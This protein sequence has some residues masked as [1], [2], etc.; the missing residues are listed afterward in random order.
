MVRAHYSH[1]SI[2]D[3]PVIWS[4]FYLARGT[5]VDYTIFTMRP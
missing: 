5:I 1:R 4:E 3:T 2:F